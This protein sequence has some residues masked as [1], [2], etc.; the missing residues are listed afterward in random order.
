MKNRTGKDF[1]K[2]VHRVEIFKNGDKEIRVDHFQVGDSNTRYIQFINT[3]RVLTVTGDY[4]NWVFCRPFHPSA[5]G[6]VSDGY[7]LEK[8]SILSEQVAATYDGDETAKEIQTLIDTGLEEY[9]YEG[10]EL[11]RMKEWYTDLLSYTDDEYEYVYHA[12]RDYGRPNIEPETIPF[13]KKLNN[14]LNVIF[15]AFDE[16]CNRMKNDTEVPKPN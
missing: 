3:D 1:S 16:I 4:G 2:H 13:C 8:L 7:W 5:D 15:D 9:G 6:H 14:W 10:D 12:Y 11:E